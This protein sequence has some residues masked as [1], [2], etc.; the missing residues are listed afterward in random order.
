MPTTCSNTATAFVE[1]GIRDGADLIHRTHYRL[2]DGDLDGFEPSVAFFD[3]LNTAFRTSFVRAARR[4]VVPE[5]VDAAVVEA[6]G[7]T[8]HAFLE[9]PEADLRQAVL[10]EFYRRVASN[11]CAFGA[12]PADAAGRSD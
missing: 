12:S 5:P 1:F 2:V 10:P 7:E 9:R 6:S 4:P 11:Y 3:R 8:A